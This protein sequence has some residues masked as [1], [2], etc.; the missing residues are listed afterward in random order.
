MTSYLSSDKCRS[1]ARLSTPFGLSK[2]SSSR[3]D[4]RDIAPLVIPL[5]HRGEKK[6]NL[7]VGSFLDVG[8]VCSSVAERVKSQHLYRAVAAAIAQSLCRSKIVGDE[9]LPQSFREIRF[10]RF[11]L[12]ITLYTL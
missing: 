11:L 1:S 10:A 12:C 2:G 7:T 3:L 8:L 5:A 6:T 9:D 4:T